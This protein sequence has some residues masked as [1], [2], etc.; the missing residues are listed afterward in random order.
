MH[1]LILLKR[2]TDQLGLVKNF[3]TI[4][5]EECTGHYRLSVKILKSLIRD[6]HHHDSD[7]LQSPWPSWL[8]SSTPDHQIF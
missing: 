7:T 5:M 6:R 2:G 4:E 8:R 1:R 3:I